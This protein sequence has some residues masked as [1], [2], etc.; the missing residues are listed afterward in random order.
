[1]G[2]NSGF[3]GLKEPPMPYYIYEPQSVLE[4]SDYKLYYDKYITDWIIHNNR[5]DIVILDKTIKEPY[6]KDEAIP[7]SH[8]VRSTII[9]KL[10]KYT[11]LKKGL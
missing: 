9:E 11:D 5:P 3:K 7:D 4:N 8:N 2:F 10:Q 1:M 6:L